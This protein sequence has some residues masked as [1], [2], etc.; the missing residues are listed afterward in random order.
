MVAGRHEVTSFAV[1]M[2][3]ASLSE[4]LE[5]NHFKADTHIGLMAMAL[6]LAVGLASRRS[7]DG[8]ICLVLTRRL[9][10]IAC[11]WV[12]VVVKIIVQGLGRDVGILDEWK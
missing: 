2:S 11:D 8:G 10:R 5:A 7:T 1:C 9:I 6:L 12:V 4:E 3:A